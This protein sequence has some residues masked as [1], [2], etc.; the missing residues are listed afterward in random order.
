MSL[1]CARCGKDRGPHGCCSCGRYAVVQV[2]QDTELV[3]AHCGQPWP[4]GGMHY[5]CPS[6]GLVGAKWVKAEATQT[7]QDDPAGWLS[8]ERIREIKHG[9]EATEA[10]VLAL[11]G[12]VRER[13]RP[14]TVNPATFNG[15]PNPQESWRDRPPLLPV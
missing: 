6:C 7:Q 1:S 14:D 9:A 8:D 13:R 15:Q 12:E 4:L 3:C 2:A 10:E 11:A 5:R